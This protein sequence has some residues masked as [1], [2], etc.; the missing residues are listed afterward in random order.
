MPSGG[1]GSIR[2]EDAVPPATGLALWLRADSG[3]TEDGSGVSSWTDRVTGDRSASRNSGSPRL[4]EDVVN[5]KPVVRFDGNQD[6]LQIAHPVN[7]AT[8]ISITLVTAS[9]YTARPAEWCCRPD[10]TGCS[11]TYHSPFKWE[12]TG[13]WGSVYVSPAQEEVAVRFGNGEGT[14]SGEPFYP[15]NVFGDAGYGSCRDDPARDPLVA[16]L[17]PASIQ[18][19]F[20][21]TTAV[22]HTDAIELFVEGEPVWTR[23]M[24]GGKSAISNTGDVAN[25]GSGS[26]DTWW[27]GDI[28]EIIVHQRALSADELATLKHYVSCRY[29]PDRL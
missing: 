12:E 24:P 14:Y 10:E 28:A 21:L 13:S 4:V 22:K 18:E 11:G 15:D 19:A 5:G 7:G 20:T 29:F 17:R 27:A 23:S 2:C 3:V 6:R 8:E 1:S 9:Q 26:Y 16:W 25:I